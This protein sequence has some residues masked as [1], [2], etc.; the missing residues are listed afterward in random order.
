MPLAVYSIARDLNQLYLYQQNHQLGL[1]V[2]TE[3][4]YLG[5]GY[6]LLLRMLYRLR[7]QEIAEL[8][9]RFCAAYKDQMAGYEEFREEWK[10]ARYRLQAYE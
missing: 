6:N 5:E 1:V 2:D 9:D 10:T 7:L 3:S 8:S 4:R